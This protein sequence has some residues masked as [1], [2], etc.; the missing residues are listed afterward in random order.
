[1]SRTVLLAIDVGN[2]NV[3]LGLF[4]YE[5]ETSSLSQHWRIT[6]RRE[7]TSD[8]VTVI[9]RSLFEQGGSQGLRDQRRHHLERGPSPAADLGARLREALRARPPG[10]RAG[11]PDRHAGALRESARGGSR[12]HR[13]LRGGL[14][15]LRRP[16]DRGRLRDGHDLRLHLV[17]RRV[18]GRRH[19]PG[20]PDRHGRAVP[21]HRAAASG[22][23]G[24]TPHGHRQDHHA[25]RCSRV[26]SSATPAWWTPWSRASAPSSAARLV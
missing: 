11:H 22:G 24:Q 9:L 7:Q 5:G 12:S 18:P 20:H 8:E 19:L 2:T 3:T 6:T 13:E 10:G 14:R 17:G 26:C 21:A 23:A 1:M 16:G 15:A 4:D 25:A